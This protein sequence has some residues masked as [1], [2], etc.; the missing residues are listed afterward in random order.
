[1]PN[2]N[3]IIENF[4]RVKILV[5]GDVMLDSYLWGSVERIS[6]EAPVPV[7][8]VQKTSVVAG[9]AANVAANIAGLGA[10][11]FLI[12]VVGVDDE[13]KILKAKLNDLKIAPDLLIG[14]A[15][16]RTTNKTRIVAHNQHI[17]RIDQETTRELDDYETGTVYEKIES[18]V[19]KVSVIIIS[20]YAKGMLT[21]RLLKRLITLGKTKNK[22]VLVDPKGKDFS[23]YKGAAILTPNQ[24]ETAEAC[25]VEPE[26]SDLIE[27]DARK[28]LD[29]LHLEALL[30]TQGE[31]GMTLLEKPDKITRL[32]S[33]A[34]KVYDVT[35]AGDTVIATFAT[36]AGSGANFSDAA[37]IANIAA[38]L[39]VEQIG[40]TAVSVGQLK[41]A[42]EI[43]SFEM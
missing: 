40:T 26:K 24:R 9:G 33:L 6:P 11:S 23:K 16:R 13:A 19:D 37:K 14:L 4:S 32:N 31:R 7:V 15:N 38:G 17:V 8:N 20:D 41:A 3:T 27:H 42:L 10:D 1:M 18:V 2:L 36:A 29:D 28:L 34:R 21:D 43:N 25:R 30:V 5:V 12:G 22:I 35:G 39:V